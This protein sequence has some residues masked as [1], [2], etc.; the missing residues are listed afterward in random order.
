MTKSINGLSVPAAEMV[1]AIETLTLRNDLKFLTL[2]PWSSVFVEGSL[3]QFRRWC[4]CCYEEWRAKGEA[5]YEP[6]IWV[7]REVQ[8][9]S[10][11]ERFLC[12]QCP[13]CN[14]TQP[15][16]AP[17]S[18]PGCCSKCKMWLGEANTPSAIRA[19][20]LQE[21]VDLEYQKWCV[22]NIGDLLATAPR[23]LTKPSREKCAQSLTY[24]VKRNS[25]NNKISLDD[26]LSI[27]P[28]QINRWRR[29]EV[30]PQLLT[31]LRICKH[32]DV[33]L[34]DYLLGKLICDS[35]AKQVRQKGSIKYYTKADW[36]LI[37][38]K[39]RRIIRNKRLPPSLSKIAEQLEV[40]IS[41]LM[42]NLTDLCNEILARR[43]SY[44]KNRYMD[45]EAE[46]DSI[47]KTKE[48]P[49]PSVRQVA[50]RVKF[51]EIAL[52]KKFPAQCE[53]ISAR[54]LEY[55]EAFK[56]ER[57]RQLEEE[58]RQIALSL[59]AQGIRPSFPKVG[60]QL[61]VPSRMSSEEART[62]LRSVQEELGYREQ[63]S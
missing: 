58:V 33:K 44:Q 4:P 8:Y 34:V 48:C 18:R 61:S 45:I 54:F 10:R 60:E 49:P 24:C 3:A 40:N 25:A 20:G 50:K 47:I 2:L 46:L 36:K 16:L 22:E 7:F 30:Q 53:I 21:D 9:C 35:S 29:G 55:C 27:S 63:L 43:E 39:L 59:H 37:A 52:V 6:L 5:V 26:F 56:V 15:L 32:S 12:S 19:E 41:T 57:R 28:K 23:L 14:Q 38:N 13:F 1:H 42:K 51:H 11:H 31:L 62:V 17:R